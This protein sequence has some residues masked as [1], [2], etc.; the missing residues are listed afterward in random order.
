MLPETGLGV[1]GAV[2]SDLALQAFGNI[3]A[4]LL[5]VFF[6]VLG[7]RWFCIAEGTIP[8][9]RAGRNLA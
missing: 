7:I 4:F 2:I 1:V 6:G 9:A 3:G 8:V 5:P